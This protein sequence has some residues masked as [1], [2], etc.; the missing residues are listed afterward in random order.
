[1]VSV[2]VA[3][4]NI[5]HSEDIICKYH[6]KFKIASVSIFFIIMLLRIIRIIFLAQ[7]LTIILVL[8]PTL[9]FIFSCCCDNVINDFALFA[10]PDKY[11]LA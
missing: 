8:S 2:R 9:L 6:M 7:K 5:D 1:M 10:L 4:I 11:E 3:S